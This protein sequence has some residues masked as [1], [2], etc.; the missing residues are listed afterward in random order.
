M[1]FDEARIRVKG[2]DGGAGIVAFRRE[3][4]VPHGGPAGGDGGRG[5]DVILVVNPRLNTL[6][7]FQ[8]RQH[9]VADSGGHGG[10]SGK[11]GKSA[12]P[13]L[14][15]VPPGTVVREAD[16]QTVLADLTA[17]G[18]RFVVAKG[19][20]GGRGNTRFKSSTNQA[21]R[22]AEKGEPGQEGW[23]ALELKLIAD[24][25]IVGVPNAGKSTFLSVVSNARPKIADYPFTTLQPNLGVVIQHD[26][27][28]VLADL[29]GLVEGAHAGVG[30]GHAF[31]R[32]VQRTRVLIHL[33]DG[34]GEDPMGDFVQ[35]NTELALFDPHLADRP[36]LVVLNKIDLPMAQERWPEV[37]QAVQGHGYE[38]FAM[39]AATHQGVEEVLG[40]AAALLAEMPAAPSTVEVP[41]F[42]P[43][44]VDD[45]GFEILREP[46]GWR[47]AGRGIERAAS[48]TYWQYDEAVMRFQRVLEA[49]G[50]RVA[51][52]EAG[53][54]TGDTVF[55][56]EYE[57]E[58]AD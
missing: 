10:S 25:G 39:S 48:M 6:Q 33:L 1:F 32:H 56:G 23:L 58:W 35:I 14:V 31:L 43:D 21:P 26:R 5:G 34:A 30:L 41:V 3:K 50:I 15:D 27:E 44:E 37:E 45:S 24:V 20:R 29:P 51:L 7:S 17:P 28:M 36:Q 55:I 13:L 9:F 52:E 18:Q 54:E 47:V 4:Y 49:M 38:V 16:S 11:T 42:Q 46:G 57:L 19:G 40:R 12:E 8:K 53:V 22:I 2:G